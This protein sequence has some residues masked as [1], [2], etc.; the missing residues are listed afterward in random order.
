[1]SCMDD[2]TM[3][4]IIKNYPPEKP[5][6]FNYMKARADVLTLCDALKGLL[7]KI[8]QMESFHQKGERK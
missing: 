8:E 3:A 5:V 1:M 6:C 7:T 4:E 2:N